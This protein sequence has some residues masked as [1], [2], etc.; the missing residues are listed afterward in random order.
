[1]SQCACQIHTQQLLYLKALGFLMPAIHANCDCTC[2]WC[3][4]LGCK[5][6]A[7]MC[8]SLGNFSQSLAC[9]KVDLLEGDPNGGFEFWGRKPACTTM[10]CAECGFGKPNGI[11]ADCKAV[12]G[13]ADRVV[14]WIRFGDQTMEDGKVHKKQQLPQAGTLSALWQEF[15]DHSGKVNS[16]AA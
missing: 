3:D 1:M 6:W 12:E 2:S 7:G 5:K 11:P 4:E 14:G 9:D 16:A 10:K 15:V 13:S 8:E